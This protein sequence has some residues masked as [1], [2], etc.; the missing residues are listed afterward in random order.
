MK[1][2]VVV[3]LSTPRGTEDTS[4]E[5]KTSSATVVPIRFRCSESQAKLGL[6]ESTVRYEPTVYPWESYNETD[7]IA[8]ASNCSV[9]QNT[10]RYKPRHYKVIVVSI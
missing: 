4:V 9:T 7:K 2:C 10:D 1:T 3:Q 6:L 8:T 5:S